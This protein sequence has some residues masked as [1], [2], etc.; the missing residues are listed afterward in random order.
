MSDADACALVEDH[1]R[2]RD[3]IAREWSTITGNPVPHW[4]GLDR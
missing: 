2:R 3:A 1:I 4:V